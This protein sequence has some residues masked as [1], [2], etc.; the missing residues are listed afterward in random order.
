MA[1]LSAGQDVLDCYCHTGAFALTAA[2]AGAKSVRGIDRSEP[3]ITLATQA[4][5]AN[6]LDRIARFEKADGCEALE[7]MNTEGTRDGTVITDI[8]ERR[9]GKERA[10]TWKYRGCP[11]ISKQ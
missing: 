11:V 5:K 8:Q 7:K 6:G 10:R 9:G 3:G 1:S 4:A 2:K